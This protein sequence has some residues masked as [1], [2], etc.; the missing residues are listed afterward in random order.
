MNLA[1]LTAAV[2]TAAS[3]ASDLP[4]INVQHPHRGKVY[5][6]GTSA[7]AEWIKIDL[8]ASYV[9][10]A[11]ILLDHTLTAGDSTIKLQGNA[12]DSW[13]SP[14]VDET[15]TYNAG[16]MAKYLSAAQTYRWWRIIFTKSA[17]GESRDIGR[18]YLG[19]YDE[20]TIPPT[21]PD[22]LQIEPQD[23]SITQRSLGGQTYSD[24]KDQYDELVI[25]FPGALSETQSG[26]L[27]SLADTCGTHTPFFISVDP[28]NKPYDWLWY[29]KATD[30]TARKVKLKK[31]ATILWDATLK[32]SEE[33]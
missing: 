32:L 26:N 15:L 9:V 17:A 23:L 20:M 12:T 3:E 31:G 10:Q 16:T 1:D 13:G 33:L 18:V 7:A 11:V 24:I 28:T 5:R 27:Q 14:S 30:L 19:P 29:V 25:E 6:T 2:V 22:G 21:Q 8:G 4:V